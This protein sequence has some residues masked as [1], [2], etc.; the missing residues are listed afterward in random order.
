MVPPEDFQP[1]NKL[2]LPKDKRVAREG[3]PSPAVLPTGVV[4]DAGGA[5]Q[6]QTQ[7]LLPHHVR[8]S[9]PHLFGGFGPKSIKPV[10]VVVHHGEIF[11]DIFG[12]PLKLSSHPLPPA[13][14]RLAASGRH[15][16]SESYRDRKA[17]P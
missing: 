7:E 12:G 8:P 2:S 15:E 11:F 1:I 4:S 10:V 3:A 5:P 14:D 9:C 13:T 6:L 17:T 16:P